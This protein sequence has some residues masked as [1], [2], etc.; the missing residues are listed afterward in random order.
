M[1]RGAARNGRSESLS[2]HHG[3]AVEVR[4]GGLGGWGLR[5]K[6]L[7]FKMLGFEVLGLGLKGL[8]PRFRVSGVRYKVLGLRF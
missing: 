8:G 2:G 5:F 3:S 1:P 6:I 7:G 4:A